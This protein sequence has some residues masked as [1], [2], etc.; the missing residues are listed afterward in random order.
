MKYSEHDRSSMHPLNK[1]YVLSVVL[2][3]SGELHK[4]RLELRELYDRKEIKRGEQEKCLSLRVRF[5]ALTNHRLP[6]SADV[7]H[8]R[9][10][11]GNGASHSLGSGCPDRLGGDPGSAQKGRAMHRELHYCSPRTS[12]VKEI[13]FFS[14]RAFTNADERVAA[15]V[16]GAAATAP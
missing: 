15:M 13:D 12:Q 11:V 6:S 1:I 9:H 5:A 2:N 14:W 3:P 16:G 8:G 7:L 10:G 4:N